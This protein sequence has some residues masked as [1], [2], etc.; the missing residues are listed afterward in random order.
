MVRIGLLQSNRQ[1]RLTFRYVIIEKWMY[2]A[3]VLLD[4][5]LVLDN[6]CEYRHK[7]SIAKTRVIGLHFCHRLCRSVFDHFDVIGPKSYGIR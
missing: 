4:N 1:R 7:L 6:L 2:I 3:L 5:A